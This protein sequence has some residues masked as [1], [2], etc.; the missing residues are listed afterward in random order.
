MAVQRRP[1]R[2]LGSGGGGAVITGARTACSYATNEPTFPPRPPPVPKRRRI[3]LSAF[4]TSLGARR[5]RRVYSASLDRETAT[6]VDRR[7]LRQKPPVHSTA[8]APLVTPT[9]LLLARDGVPR[10]M[11]VPDLELAPLLTDDMTPIG[12]DGVRPQRFGP[13]SMLARF[14]DGGLVTFL[15]SARYATDLDGAAG[16]VVVTTPELVNVVPTGNATVTSARPPKAGLFELVERAL[17][18]QR[19]E[20]LA[21]YRSPSARV[22]PTAVVDE[23]V[24]IDDDATVGPGAVLLANT[25]VGPGARVKPNAVLGDDGFET[26]RVGDAVRVVNHAGGVWLGAGVH[27]GALSCVDKGLYGDFT[28]LGD[29]TQTDD[30]VYVAHNVVCGQRCTLTAGVAVLGWTQLGDD[31]WLGPSTSVNQLLQIG[32]AA[33]VGTGSVVRHDVASH[34]LVYGDTA[35]QKGWACSCHGRLEKTGDRQFE[36]PSCRRR[37]RVDD[38]QLTSTE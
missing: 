17:R 3:L 20:R 22:H 4:S 18:E 29:Y 30:Q 16:H 27:I 10:A 8:L 9:D 6:R 19:F 28:V 35:R 25:Y 11:R 15:D 33:Y 38:G 26:V 2:S 34:A 37:Y 36:C 5:A 31:V 14:P 23:H 21:E 12:L 7:R 32:T 24:Y 1:R 13:L